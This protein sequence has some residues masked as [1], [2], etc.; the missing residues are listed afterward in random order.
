M[1]NQVTNKSNIT[2]PQ[3]AFDWYDEY[4]HGDINRRTFM[5]RL[6]SLSI[7]GL[8]LGVL[9]SSLIPDYAKAEQVSFNDPD[10]HATYAEFDSPKGYGKGGGYLVVPKGLEKSVPAVLVVHENRG[11]NPYVKDVARR[12]AKAGMIAFAPDAL[13]SLGGY[14]GNDDEGRKMQ[15][16]LERSKIEQDFMAAAK[17][18]KSHEK[19]T[20]KLGVVGFCFGGYIS[21][22]LAA[23][24]PNDIDAAVPYYGT[25]AKGELQAKVK[26]PIQI[27]FA[28]LDKR[29]NASW[30]EYESVL[31][32]NNAKYE[33]HIYAK[34]QHGFHNDST[35]R[36]SPENA[37]LA[38]SRTLSF[39]KQHL[40]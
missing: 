28:E 8:S 10:I 24:M 3:T 13:F 34:A 27:H 5:T 39:F 17:W 26:G 20:D 7:A 31:K 32:A 19:T 38:W 22:L 16:S 14:P 1:K 25:P 15:R 30:P 33:A 37:E 11:L 6:S 9:T 40:G 36:Y 12:I 23:S 29:V 21:N 18:L 2:I 35:S 4:A